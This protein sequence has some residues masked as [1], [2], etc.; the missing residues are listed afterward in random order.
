MI[1]QEKL[2]AWSRKALAGEKG[3]ELLFHRNGEAICVTEKYEEDVLAYK[4]I[5]WNDNKVIFN[6]SWEREK[7]VAMQSKIVLVIKNEKKVLLYDGKTKIYGIGIGAKENIKI[8]IYCK[9][10]YAGNL[11]IASGEIPE[12]RVLSYFRSENQDAVHL[13]VTLLSDQLPIEDAV[14]Q[15]KTGDKTIDEEA[16]E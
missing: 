13:L 10:E 11:I 6:A 3:Y 5:V 16:G 2:Q 9:F 1:L 8:L 12:V 14:S 4:I 15:A 7:D